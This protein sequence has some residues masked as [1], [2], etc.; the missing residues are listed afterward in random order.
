MQINR[1]RGVF[2][3]FDDVLNSC[4]VGLAK[5]AKM[6]W[7]AIQRNQLQAEECVFVDDIQ[8]FVDLAESL[9]IRGILFKSVEQLKEE[10]AKLGVV[11]E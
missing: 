8:E 4:E 5:D 6:L 3:H 11:I 7:L 10:L 1:R 2:D 9:G